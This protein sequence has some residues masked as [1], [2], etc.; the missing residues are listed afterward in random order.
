MRNIINILVHAFTLQMHSFTCT[1]YP[2]TDNTAFYHLWCVFHKSDC[3]MNH[4]EALNPLALQM[5]LEG[6][7]FVLHLMDLLHVKYM[8][9]P[10]FSASYQRHIAHY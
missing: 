10:K 4:W 1:M 2:K 8:G 7:N 6:G 5:F 9:S 3:G